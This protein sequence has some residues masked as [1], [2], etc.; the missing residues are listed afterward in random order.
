M[1]KPMYWILVGRVPQ[2]AR[3]EAWGVWFEN[4]D[5]RRV[6]DDKIERIDADPVRVSTVFL[7]LDHS[8]G[9]GPPLLFESMVFGG[10][11]DGE[12][13]R[14]CT[15]DEAERGHKHLLAESVTEGELV[16][17]QAKQVIT[18]AKAQS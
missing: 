2:P 14:Y 10:P 18:L 6:G 15:L 9:D 13:H 4:F 5:N 3:L 16:A 8:F 17:W 12:Q 7:G 1:K 11:L